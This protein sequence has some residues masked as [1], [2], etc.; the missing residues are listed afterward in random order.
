MADFRKDSPIFF[1]WLSELHRNFLYK[2]KKG[3]LFLLK[4]H[5]FGHFRRKFSNIRLSFKG[6]PDQIHFIFEIIVGKSRSMS[7][8][9]LSEIDLGNK[10]AW[11]LTTL[12]N[13]NLTPKKPYQKDFT[14]RVA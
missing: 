10:M 6:S 1:G 8:T 14:V 12:K 13:L 2:I 9:R 4:I 7:D 3:R 11:I 5:K